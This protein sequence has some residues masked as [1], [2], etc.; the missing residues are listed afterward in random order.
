MRVIAATNVPLADL[1]EQKQMRNDF[2]YRIAVIPIRLIPLRQ[3]RQDIPLLVDDFLHQH[4][5]A[6]QKGI[7]GISRR[8]M[9]RLMQNPWPGNIREL[10]NV[11]EKALVLTTGRI[12]ESVDLPKSRSGAQLN[13]N[14]MP[15]AVSLDQWL[16]EQEKQYLIR[17]LES[18]GGKVAATA[19]S[20]GLGV[21]T[22]SRKMRLYGLQKRDFQQKATESFASYQDGLSTP[23]NPSTLRPR[24]G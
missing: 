22:L 12:I 19:K 17:Q 14:T 9:D 15:S 20:C 23:K 16:R 6:V 1:V 21:R 4:S 13:G 8:A 3:R 7:T 24:N 10:Q 5:V 18:F 11:L 2:Y